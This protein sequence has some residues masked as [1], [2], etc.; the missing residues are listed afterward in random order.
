MGKRPLAGVKERVLIGFGIAALSLVAVRVCLQPA[1]PL[2]GS[3]LEWIKSALFV[4]AMV[5]LAYT[6]TDEALAFWS[7]LGIHTLQYGPIFLYLNFYPGVKWALWVVGTM[8]LSI[9]VICWLA[10]SH[11]KKWKALDFLYALWLAIGFSVTLGQQGILINPVDY[12]STLDLVPPDFPIRAILDIRVV[13]TLLLA[14]GFLIRVVETVFLL[15]NRD[16]IPPIPDWKDISLPDLDTSGIGG[17]IG[18]IMLPCLA[19]LNVVAR[20]LHWLVNYSWIV[21]A[22]VVRI[23]VHIVIALTNELVEVT[24]ATPVLKWALRSAAAYL[25]I[26]ATISSFAWFSPFLR[27]YLLL[28]DVGQEIVPMMVSLVSA[29][30]FGVIAFAHTWLY[31][32]ERNGTGSAEVTACLLLC[33]VLAGAICFVAHYLPLGHHVRGFQHVGPSLWLTGLVATATILIG[34]SRSTPSGNASKSSARAA[35]R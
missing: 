25:L 1:V 16:P 19:A 15:P 28:E 26:Y 21:I 32:S 27:E 29:I 18:A 24:V 23:L 35:G 3:D 30:A 11:E 34:I 10:A 4:C 13:L 14:L 2:P 22:T 8:A 7:V 9:F 5:V 17:L 12:R 33:C 20:I 6:S 31:T